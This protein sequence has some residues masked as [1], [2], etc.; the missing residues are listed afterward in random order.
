MAFRD[1][2][3][4]RMNATVGGV[5][6]CALAILM[7]ANVKSWLQTGTVRFRS[8]TG[9][10]ELFITR[11]D[12]PVFYWIDVVGATLLGAAAG[13]TGVCLLAVVLWS[14]V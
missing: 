2:P 8:Q 6:L 14:F 7:A 13:I 12:E 4:W 1:N 5:A 11:D 9:M 10:M 3:N